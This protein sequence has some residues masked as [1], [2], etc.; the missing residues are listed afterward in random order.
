MYFCPEQLKSSTA[1][2]Q[3]QSPCLVRSGPGF[4]PRESRYF[5]I[6]PQTVGT[7]PESQFHEFLPL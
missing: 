5:N 3:R 7:E 2:A 6:F 1:V 4:G